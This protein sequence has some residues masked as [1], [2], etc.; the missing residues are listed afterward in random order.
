[1]TLPAP[2]ATNLTAR[3]H[4]GTTG[5][6]PEFAL[7]VPREQRAYLIQGK[8]TFWNGP[9]RDIFSPLWTDT[10]QGPSP[11]RIGSSPL[12]TEKEALDA[13]DAACRA[14]DHGRGPWPSMD[15]GKRI[16]RFSHFIERVIEKRREIVRLLMWEIGKSSSECDWEFDR[17]IAYMRQTIDAIQGFSRSSSRTLD[18]E[19]ITGTTGRVP[20]GTVLCMGPFNYPLYETFTAVAPALL[21]GNTVIIKPP[22]FGGLIF[23]LILDDLRN[24]F[25]EGSVNVIYGDGQHIIPPLM[26]SGRIDVLAFIGTS[27][28]ATYLRSLHPKPHRLR[29]LLGLE[30]KNPAIIL[31]D[32]D[33]DTAVS[34]CAK[35]S[36]AFNGQRCAAIKIIF[37]HTDIAALFT[38]RLTETI[39]A[40]RCGM[41]WDNDVVITPIAE[42][43][44]PEYLRALIDDALEHGARIAH[45]GQ[46]VYEKGLFRPVLL[47]PVTSRMRI[48]RE[49]QFGPVV[50]VVPFSNI[51]TAVE[52]VTESRY[53]QQVS[54]FG[55]DAPTLKKLTDVLAYQVSRININ[56]KCQRSPDAFPFTGRKDSAE[57]VLSVS[58]ALH[59]F[60]APVVTAH[61][62]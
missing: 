59:A 33:L 32:S 51:E 22:R 6:T 13:L 2:E 1:M 60:T 53:G 21:T 40:A 52:Y 34:E 15:I 27:S 48:Y 55:N 54:L 38:K 29:C 36:L 10:P 45:A 4:S 26:M 46:T 31:P 20:L 19:G 56:C 42:P 3:E 47:Y 17:T 8:I 41:P 57:G 44:K 43:E 39:T 9:V 24:S 25:P 50:P 23:G 58:D 49:E 37:V 35:G 12:N 61:R 28:T 16:S 14:F 30:A 7:P 62:S 5:V 18:L 11:L